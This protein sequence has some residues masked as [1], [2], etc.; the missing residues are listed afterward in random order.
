MSFGIIHAEML[1]SSLA[2]ILDP[3]LKIP[4]ARDVFAWLCPTA[5]ARTRGDAARTR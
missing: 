5:C 1:G 2:E 4:V 3:V